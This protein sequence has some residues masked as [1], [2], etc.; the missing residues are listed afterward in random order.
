MTVDH[1][2]SK[3]AAKSEKQSDGIRPRPK[4]VYGAFRLCIHH[5]VRKCCP[6]GDQCSFP[7]SEVERIAW[8][9]DRSKGSYPGTEMTCSSQSNGMNPKAVILASRRSRRWQGPGGAGMAQR[10]ERSP[11]TNLSGIRFPD[12]AS[13]V[14]QAMKTSSSL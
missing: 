2:V 8:E 1:S 5:S 14:G 12:P 6:A 10:R 9:E 4:N 11:S 3:A 13:Y 7:H